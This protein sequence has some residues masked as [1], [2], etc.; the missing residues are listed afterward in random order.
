[1]GWMHIYGEEEGKSGMEGC[2]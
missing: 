2:E 1:M